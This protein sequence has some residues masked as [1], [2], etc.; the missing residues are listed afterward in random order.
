MCASVGCT[1]GVEYAGGI[2][3]GRTPAGPKQRLTLVVADGLGRG[4]G[5]DTP[6]MGSTTRCWSLGVGLG[7]SSGERAV[8]GVAVENFDMG[9]MR[10]GKEGACGCWATSKGFLRVC[11][12]ECSG[13]QEGWNG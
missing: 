5:E 8:P 1:H 12:W 9:G 11:A 10:Q 13:R 2:G 6:S 3:A 4:L 7:F